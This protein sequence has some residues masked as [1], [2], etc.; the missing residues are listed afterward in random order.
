M[1]RER[2]SKDAATTNDVMQKL[3]LVKRNRLQTEK[4]HCEVF[5]FCKKYK[6]P[7]YVG[8]V[9]YS[10]KYRSTDSKI[11]LSIDDSVLTH[12]GIKQDDKVAFLKAK[13]N[14][15][16]SLDEEV[17]SLL[18]IQEDQRK[19]KWNKKLLTAFLSFVV[20]A[21]GLYLVFRLMM[22]FT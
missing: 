2:Q 8:E 4:Q 21:C 10:K 11:F 5:Q 15:I 22:F 13:E 17:D 6:L 19:L 14:H 20:L 16:R 1:Q 3:R 9:L 7:E 12:M 18:R